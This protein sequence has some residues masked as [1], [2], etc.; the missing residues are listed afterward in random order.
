M[1]I[2]KKKKQIGK[3]CLYNNQT[4]QSNSPIVEENNF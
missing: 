4:N 3:K 2:R 1:N